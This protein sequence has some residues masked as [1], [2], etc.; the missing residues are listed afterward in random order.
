M[1][2][3]DERIG[4]L[5][6]HVTVLAPNKTEDSATGELIPTWSPVAGL[7]ASVKASQTETQRGNKMAR[8]T[9]YEV[10]IRYRADLENK[11]T[12]RLSI[13][14]DVCEISKSIDPTRRKRWLQITAIS[15][16]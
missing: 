1:K 6:E 16:V 13:N 10:I 3:G 15:T 9:T 4:K 2:G 5:R 14:G 11:T 8:V 7:P 12:H